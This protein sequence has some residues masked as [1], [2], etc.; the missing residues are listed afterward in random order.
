MLRTNWRTTPAARSGVAAALV[1]PDILR[2]HRNLPACWPPTPVG[3]AGGEVGGRR[4]GLQFQLPFDSPPRAR[5]GPTWVGQ[6][7]PG[8]TAITLS[9]PSLACTASRPRR[10][11][12][13]VQ[14]LAQL[15]RSVSGKSRQLV[16]VAP[17]SSYSET[18]IGQRKATVLPLTYDDMVPPA[19][20]RGDPILLGSAPSPA[21]TD[22]RSCGL[23]II[24][25]SLKAR[26]T[27]PCHPWCE[28]QLSGS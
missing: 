6:R 11:I 17:T 27:T 2:R 8:S 5:R 4:P 15:Q 22:N 18:I 24:D 14:S 3:R 21:G 28:L 20:S 26:V 16:E 9:N 23:V 10:T 7:K 25:P 12:P 1:R 19:G 13:I